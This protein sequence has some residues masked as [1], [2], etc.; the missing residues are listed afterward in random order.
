M[1]VHNGKANK[2]YVLLYEALG[3]AILINAI[4]LGGAFGPYASP[5]TLMGI[6][7]M[8][9]PVS[10]AHFNPA[11]TVAVWIRRS[12]IG[13]D[14]FFMLQIIL[15][16]ILGGC[17]GCAFVSFSNDFSLKDV[18]IPGVAKLCPPKVFSGKDCVPKDFGSAMHMLWAEIFGTFLLVAVIMGVKFQDGAGKLHL[19]AIIIS[20]TLAAII[21]QYGG[22]SG[23]C[24][25]PAV[26]VAQTIFMNIV[27]SDVSFGSI[28]IYLAGPLIGGLLGGLWSKL[29]ANA[30][31]A[32]SSD[33]NSV[34][35]D[36]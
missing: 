27:Y 4:N 32:A 34:L 31:A 12:E 10:G 26:A 13:K 17:L 24:F 25:N 5:L 20:C 22:V 29:D 35:D 33:Y 11:V 19:N 2:K 15:A 36:R 6:I 8:L 18:P 16:Q 14:A 30:R 9:D 1:E 7:F 21:W 28:Y 23:A 3:T